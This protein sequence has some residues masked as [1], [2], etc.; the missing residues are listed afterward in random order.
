MIPENVKKS[1]FLST[2]YSKQ[3]RELEKPKFEIGDRVRISKYDLHFKSGY[4][5]QFTKEVVEIVAMSSAKPPTYTI[6]NE[7]DEITRGKFYRR[8]LIKVI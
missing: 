3:L 6:E 1:D 7:Q 8:E 5:P 4:K 2:L